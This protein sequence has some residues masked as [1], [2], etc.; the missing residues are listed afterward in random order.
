MT[1]DW[2]VTSINAKQIADPKEFI[3]KLET[4][5]SDSIQTVP[6]PASRKNIE[7]MNPFRHPGAVPRRLN[8]N[9]YNEN[10]ENHNEKK[11][12]EQYS[13][14]STTQANVRQ[15]DTCSQIP[16]ETE[17]LDPNLFQRHT[18]VIFGFS[19]ESSL[20]LS[21][22]IDDTGGIVVD[23]KDLSNSIDY[24]IVPLDTYNLN[25]FP[26][27]AKEILTDLWIVSS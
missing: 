25:E 19:E 8:L 5:N 17:E 23:E 14:P 4:S 3:Y 13:Q 12:L 22:E 6:S 7:S 10:I 11:L 16:D 2:L 26:H 9:D 1:V 21:G 20:Q 24:L 18:F 27:K 15:E